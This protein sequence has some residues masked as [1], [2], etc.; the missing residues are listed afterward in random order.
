MGPGAGALLSNL[1][2]LLRRL[3]GSSRRPIGPAVAV[4]CDAGYA[5]LGLV[6]AAAS[7]GQANVSWAEAFHQAIGKANASTNSR[8]TPE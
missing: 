7:Q 6:S 5:K 2:Q 8:G 3:L 1:T 4:G